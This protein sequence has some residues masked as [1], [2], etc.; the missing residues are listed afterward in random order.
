RDPA[1]ELGVRG[2]VVAVDATAE[3]GDG[4]AARLERAAVRLCV[5]AT[6]ESA[7][8]DE[9]GRGE[10]APEGA[11]DGCAVARAGAGA[12]DGDGRAR[13]QLRTGVAAQEEA[14]R[15]V[16]DG[17]EE[18]RKPG[19]GAAEEAETGRSEPLAGGP[20]VEAAHV[21][22]P[23]RAERRRDEMRSGLGRV[24][25]E[26]QLVHAASSC[27]ARYANASA[28]CSGSTASAPARAAIVRARRAT[29]A[30]PRPESASRS[31]AL[32]SSVSA[33]GT[34]CGGSLRSRARAA[35]TRSR[36][37]VDGSPA[38]AASSEARAR[39]TVRTRSKRSRS[40]RE[41]LSR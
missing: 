27:G 13:E 35:S 23:A 19:L 8:N 15:R 30:R 33:A 28:T 32:E 1:R 34:R 18:R 25:R 2:R 40:A 26:R 11:R 16:V 20:L 7:D 29:R 6:G 39:G 22:G 10:L 38:G 14:R 17:G 31:T 41:S 9:P 37:A 36:T 5:H 24:Q 21:A 3:D 4:R 12:D